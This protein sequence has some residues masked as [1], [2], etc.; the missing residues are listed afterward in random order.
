MELV[1]PAGNLEKLRYA[2]AYGADA[3]YIGLK[4]FSLRVKA[5]NFYENEY[6]TVRTLKARYPRK[7]LFCALNISFHNDDIDRFLQDI[8]YFKAYPFDAFIIQDMGMVRILQKHFPNAALHLSTQAN[9]INREAVKMYR[10]SG[11]RRVVL[12][13]EASLAEIAEI[14]DTVPDMELE[15]F[16][17]GAMCIAYSG[18]CLMSAYMNGRS[19]NAGF[20]SHSCRWE[21]RLL[22]AGGAQE[23]AQSGPFALE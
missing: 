10:D 18:R 14:K 5:D 13:R 22:Q 12:G 17:H 2:Y 19:A 16:V 11:F 7:K 4:R 6:E 9:C 8:D 15:V 23:A 3:A 21:Y 1:S 20:C